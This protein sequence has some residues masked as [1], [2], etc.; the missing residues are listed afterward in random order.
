MSAGLFHD[1]GQPSCLM[2][3]DG[4]FGHT[5]AACTVRYTLPRGRTGFPQFRRLEPKCAGGDGKL[6]CQIDN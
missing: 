1:Q 3:S 2:A 5:S 6:T 4:L